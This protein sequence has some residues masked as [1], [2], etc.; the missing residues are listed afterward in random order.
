M[1][2]KQNRRWT[3]AECLEAVYPKADRGRMIYL[4][5]LSGVVRRMK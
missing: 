2:I 3:S 4:A 1:K 5:V